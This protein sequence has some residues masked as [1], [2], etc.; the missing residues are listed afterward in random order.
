MTTE[1][2]LKE[3][4]RKNRE[5]FLSERAR[6]EMMVASWAESIKKVE[7][8]V[9]DS[10]NLPEVITLQTL[11]PE[12]YVE[13]PNQAIYEEQYNAAME[14]LNKVNTIADEYNKEAIRCLSEYQAMSS[15][16]R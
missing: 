2:E 8:G 3:Q 10:V 16:L 15:S 13:E 7:A 5:N 12:L 6:Q 14:L 4:I 9:L 1:S 11:I